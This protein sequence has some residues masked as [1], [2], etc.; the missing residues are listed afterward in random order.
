MSDPKE[1]VPKVDKKHKKEKKASDEKKAKK[2]RKASKATG[3][4][5]ANPSDGF[6]LFKGKQSQLDDIFGK[7]VSTSAFSCEGRVLI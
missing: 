4:A 7:G 2:E 6:Q 3:D 5:V 1:T